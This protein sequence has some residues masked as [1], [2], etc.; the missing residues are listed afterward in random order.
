MVF[1]D[2]TQ[3]IHIRADASRHRCRELT[4]E[5]TT[6][7]VW[8]KQV[9]KDVITLMPRPP[10]TPPRPVAPAGLSAAP[11][12]PAGS[13]GSA[14]DVSCAICLEHAQQEELAM[15]KGCDHSYCGAHHA[16][17]VMRSAA[18]AALSMRCSVQM[19]A[20]SGIGSLDAYCGW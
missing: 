14:G 7:F 6:A 15:V 13:Q 19:E 11:S 8:R 1:N 18:E 17:V 2:N 10:A 3:Y 16:H 9:V 5:V 4:R 12:S 20:A